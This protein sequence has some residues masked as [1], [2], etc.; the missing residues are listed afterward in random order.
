[1]E[2]SHQATNLGTVNVIVG[3]NEQLG[4]LPQNS[5]ELQKHLTGHQFYDAYFHY[6]AVSLA[7]DFGVVNAWLQ[8]AFCLL[9]ASPA[10][11]FAFQESPLDTRIQD[12]DL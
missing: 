6:A 8:G 12:C 11:E 1:M 3:M 2:Q 9:P 4:C 5:S 7:A 10:A